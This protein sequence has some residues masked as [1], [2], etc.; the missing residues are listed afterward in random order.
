MSF[1]KL[2]K[3][4]SAVIAILYSIGTMS[5]Q[6]GLYFM[7]EIPFA[8]VCILILY[9]FAKGKRRKWEKAKNIFLLWQ[10]VS[11]Q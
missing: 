7:A 11:L 1:F 8:F 9:F 6:T 4:I 2:D 3:K 5:P 10:Q